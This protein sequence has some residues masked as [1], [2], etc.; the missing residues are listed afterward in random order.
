[1][2]TIKDKILALIGCSALAIIGLSL[3]AF[4]A[5]EKNRCNFELL[6][7]QHLEASD[8][9]AHIRWDITETRLSILRVLLARA[10]P[11][12]RSRCKQSVVECEEK[13]RDFDLQ[14]A[15]MSKLTQ[16]MSSS[17]LS[18]EKW[19]Q[20]HRSI[21]AYRQLANQLE[22]LVKTMSLT[23]D[24]QALETMWSEYEGLN[25]GLM[26]ERDLAVKELNGMIDMKGDEANDALQAGRDAAVQL[27][28]QMM[29][30]VFSGLCLVILLGIYVLRSTMR[31]LGGDPGEAAELVKRIATGDLGAKIVLA[32]GDETSLMANMKTLMHNT[33][34]Q[35]LRA[36]AIGKGELSQDAVLLSD[37]DRLGGAINTMTRLLRT[38]R[39]ESERR[40]WLQEGQRQLSTGLASDLSAPQLAEVAIS[41]LSRY[42]GAG[43]GV[44]FQFDP[45]T[46]MLERLGSY[47]YTDNGEEGQQRCR[48]GEGAIGQV[49]Q[50]KKPLIF[51]T[52][53]QASP[54]IRTGTTCGPALCTYTFPLLRDGQLLGVPEVASTE[55]FDDMKQEC[56]VASC[57]MIASS[58]FV[59]LQRENIL[60]VDDDPRNLFVITAALEQNGAQVSTAING[61]R[62]LDF[63]YQNRVDLVL[64]DIMMPEMDGYEAI[65]LLRADPALAHLPVVALTAKALP[66][67]RAKIMAAGADD[68]VS[69][70][71]DYDILI[72]KVE[73]WSRGRN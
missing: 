31:Q 65:A 13:W 38:A 50:E 73:S 15:A 12:L 46:E 19:K 53:T 3:T 66:S 35:A 43:R 32:H 42:L 8:R 72:S 18:K 26:F 23:P 59:V 36:D 62:A 69:K 21:S 48:L 11:D 55:A 22:S 63:L 28:A 54:L 51:T 47:M 64:M 71:V 27:S 5:M 30:A 16:E 29:V 61:R 70:P 52:I 37:Q 57:D 40:E 17:A 6:T 67:D 44:F 68:F 25:A 9:L 56:L 2:T 49:G 45:C 58:L 14:A 10:G 7:H 24:T 20:C 41:T 4:Y 1:M 39:A 60:V 33:E 34:L